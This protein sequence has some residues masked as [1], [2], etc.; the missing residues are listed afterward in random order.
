MQKTLNLL[1]AFFA[2]LLLK[3]KQKKPF[4]SPTVFA[5]VISQKRRENQLQKIQRNVFLSICSSHAKN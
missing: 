2:D 1:A 5:N 4:V 3:E